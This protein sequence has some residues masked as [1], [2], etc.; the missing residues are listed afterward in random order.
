MDGAPEIELV[1]EVD[2]IEQQPLDRRAEAF[3]GIHDRLEAALHAS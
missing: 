1:D 2:V 3:A